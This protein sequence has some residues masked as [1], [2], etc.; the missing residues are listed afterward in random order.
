MWKAEMQKRYNCCY[1]DDASV[2]FLCQDIQCSTSLK[3]KWVRNVRICNIYKHLQDFIYLLKM[4]LFQYQMMFSSHFDMS[5]GTAV[6][7]C[8]RAQY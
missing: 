4:I 7:R 5:R 6:H 1:H 2:L 3:A 8:G